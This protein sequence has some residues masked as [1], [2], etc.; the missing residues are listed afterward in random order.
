MGVSPGAEQIG[1]S[2]RCFQRLKWSI[3]GHYLRWLCLIHCS[4]VP[5][6]RAVSLDEH[7]D[8]PHLHDPCD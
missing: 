2:I 1:L 3:Q 8:A 6:A 7:R 5:V 4:Y